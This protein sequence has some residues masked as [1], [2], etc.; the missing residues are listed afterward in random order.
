MLKKLRKMR[1]FGS[2]MDTACG[3]GVMGSPYP[4]DIGA[5]GSQYYMDMG[6][7]VSRTV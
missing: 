2:K 5:P 4:Y 3:T 1:T 6:P 7:G